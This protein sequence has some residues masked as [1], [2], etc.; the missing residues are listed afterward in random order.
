MCARCSSNVVERCLQLAGEADRESVVHEILESCARRLAC[1]SIRVGR[2]RHPVTLLVPCRDDLL[3]LVQH[4]YAN[5]VLQRA[6][7]VGSKSAQARIAERLRWAPRCA[8]V[9]VGSI[10]TDPPFFSIR[11]HGKVLV[12]S[13]GGR[14]LLSRMDRDGFGPKKRRNPRS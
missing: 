4:Q 3:G 1:P 12:K 5:Y 6:Y 9:S 2:S 7:S 8:A 14:R 10:L 11:P 13:S